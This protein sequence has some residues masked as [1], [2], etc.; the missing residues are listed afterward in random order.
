M[1]ASWARLVTKRCEDVWHVVEVAEG[2]VIFVVQRGVPHYLQLAFP[3]EGPPQLHT[4]QRTGQVLV[5]SAVA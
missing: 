2:Q 5:R 1:P 3:F 4:E